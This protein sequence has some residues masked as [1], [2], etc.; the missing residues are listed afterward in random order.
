[1]TDLEQ[2]LYTALSDINQKY[3]DLASHHNVGEAAKV[4]E[5]DKPQWVDLTPTIEVDQLL[6]EVRNERIQFQSNIPG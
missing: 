3:K 4:R 5:S 6:E 1:M 2:K